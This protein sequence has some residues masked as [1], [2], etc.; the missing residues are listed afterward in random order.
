M[1]GNEFQGG[2]SV[3]F[4]NAEE[5]YIYFRQIMLYERITVKDLANKMN[6]SQSAVSMAFKQKNC[7]TDT[8]REMAEAIG[9]DL[10][11]DFVPKQ[12]NEKTG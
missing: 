2:V 12:D 10:I 1:S 6:K 8:L 9:Y 3:K 4:T 7:T 11:I 5:L